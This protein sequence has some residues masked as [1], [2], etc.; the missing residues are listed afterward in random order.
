MYARTLASV[1]PRNLVEEY[2]TIAYT[3]NA[4]RVR[5]P[6]HAHTVAV[7]SALH[8]LSPPRGTDNVFFEPDMQLAFVLAASALFASAVGTPV[9]QPSSIEENPVTVST[10][11]T[12][13]LKDRSPDTGL[14]YCSGYWRVYH[15]HAGRHRACQC[16]GRIF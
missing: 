5:S 11:T 10:N 8:L 14:T 3:L 13:T 1:R 6:T 15:L 12:T 2:K 16:C 9:R 7:S 4:P